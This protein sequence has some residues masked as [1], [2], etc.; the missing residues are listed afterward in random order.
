MDEISK[1][2]LSGTTP[3]PPKF[4]TNVTWSALAPM[5]VRNQT[6]NITFFNM[7]AETLRFGSAGVQHSVCCRVW[8]FCPST[9]WYDLILYDSYDLIWYN[10][11]WSVLIWYDMICYDIL[12]YDMWCT[13]TNVNYMSDNMY[14]PQYK[15]YCRKHCVIHDFWYMIYDVWYVY[16]VCIRIRILLYTYILYIYNIPYTYHLEGCLQQDFSFR[17][18]SRNCRPWLPDLVQ[19]Q[20]KRLKFISSADG[21]PCWRNSGKNPWQT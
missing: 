16:S 12:W 6:P 9:V 13:T 1:L 10:L 21:G 5:D 7:R 17:L 18:L 2:I 15:I 19:A 4:S 20:R 8:T 11:I 14:S 3:S